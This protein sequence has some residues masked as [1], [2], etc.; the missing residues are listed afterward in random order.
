MPQIIGVRFVVQYYLVG[1][2]VRDQLL[3]R[4]PRERDWLVIGATGAELLA[5]G[6]K[7][8]GKDFPIFLHPRSGE[9]YALPRGAEGTLIADLQR[10]DLT[11]NAIARDPEGKLIDPCGGVADIQARVLR[12]TGSAFADDPL[13]ILR[14]ARFAAQLPDFTLAP[15]P[16]AYVQ[17]VVANGALAELVPERIWREWEKALMTAVPDRFLTTLQA[18]KALGVIAPGLDACWP[19]GQAALA[20]CVAHEGDV[21]QRFAALCL[22]L[23]SGPQAAA[24]AVTTGLKLGAPS[25]VIQLAALSVRFQRWFRTEPLKPQ[26]ALVLL[27]RLDALRRPQRWALILQVQQ[28]G[29]LAPQ[30]VARWQQA[31]FA[32]LHT[33]VQPLLAQG[34]SG[35]VLGAA[36]RR[37]RCVAIACSYRNTL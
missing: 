4:T 18:C 29:G 25:A 1:G 22:A 37:A 10:R 28:A 32:A 31:A 16:L 12:H 17:G 21:A 11:I 27:E 2:A 23:G 13:R 26:Q 5:Q 34:L 35:T 30:Q 7:P 36:L 9:E 3:G 20:Y 24:A 15:A 14:L 33:P 8:V 19:A 6:F